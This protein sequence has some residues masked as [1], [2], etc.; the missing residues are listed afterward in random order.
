MSHVDRHIQW[1]ENE[2]E[3]ETNCDLRRREEMKRTK[4][5]INGQ[6][7]SQTKQEKNKTFKMHFHS[8]NKHDWTERTKWINS[9]WVCNRFASIFGENHSHWTDVVLN[10]EI[11]RKLI[12]FVL[13]FCFDRF[14]TKRMTFL[15]L[16][17]V[18][19][20]VSAWTRWNTNSIISHV[21]KIGSKKKSEIK[22][23]I[24]ANRNN[25]LFFFFVLLIE[26]S[27]FYL[28]SFIRL[29]QSQR[30][31]N[32]CFFFVCVCVIFKVAETINSIIKNERLH[33]PKNEMQDKKCVQPIRWQKSHFSS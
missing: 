21:V 13:R 28:P 23:A 3:R 24:N 19:W 30:W 18:E 20:W 33:Q 15:C 7:Q 11:E 22:R 32:F 31:I 4:N 8:T 10:R 6:R 1:V 26:W 27:T 9:F 29:N 16:R 14:I 17:E 5:E 2:N 12:V 25:S